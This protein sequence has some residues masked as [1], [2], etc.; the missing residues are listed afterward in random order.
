MI[1]TSKLLTALLATSLL[2]VAQA[3]DFGVDSV[4]AELGTTINGST[5]N[6]GRVGVQWDWNVKWFETDNWFLGGYWDLSAAYW[7]GSGGH[8]LAD[9]GFTPVFRYQQK[10]GSSGVS[11]YVEAAIGAHIL[12][13]EDITSNKKFS[14]NFQFGDHVGAGLRIGDKGQYDFSFRVQHLSNAGIDHP[15][16]G[17]NFG[18]ARFQYHF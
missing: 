2:S 7:H 8:D 1:K 17:I 3:A 16:P 6:M 13:S 18:E 9:I 5:V 11:P 15:N 12:S 4:S 14:T 10:I